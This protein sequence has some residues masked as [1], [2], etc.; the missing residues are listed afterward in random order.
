MA[1]SPADVSPVEPGFGI[2]IPDSVYT[3]RLGFFSMDANVPGLSRVIL[4]KLNM[5][6]FEDYS[7]AFD[8]VDHDILL[9]RCETVFGVSDTALI[10]FKSY[11]T[12]P[13][14][15]VSLRASVS[16]SRP[17]VHQTLVPAQTAQLPLPLTGDTCNAF[18]LPTGVSVRNVVFPFFSF[19]CGVSLYW[20]LFM[21]HVCRHAFC[22]AL[23]YCYRCQNVYYCSK[24]CQRENWPEHKKFCQQLR[25][26]AIDR[27]VEWLVFTGDIPFPSVQWPRPVAEVGG[28]EDW[29]FM[30][31]DLGP[32]L[33]AILACRHMGLLWDNAGKPRPGDAELRESVKRVASEFLSRPLALGLGLRLFGLD[34]GSRALT[35]H[36]V[37]ASH[38]ETLG[39]RTTDLDELSRMFPGHQGLEVVMVGPEVVDGPVLRPPLRALG[40]RGKVYIS[41]YKGLYHQFWEELVEQ[42]EAARPDLVVGFHPALRTFIQRLG[43]SRRQQLEGFHAA[44][45]LTE[46]WLPTLLLLRDYRIPSLFTMYNEQE[47]KYSL[48]ILTELEVQIVKCGVNPFASLKPEQVQSS[49]NKPPVYCN[50]HYVSFHG[51]LEGFEIQQEEE[52]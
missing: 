34:P 38:S 20:F 1:H 43:D 12:D 35:V 16:H 25:L 18:R 46:G 19:Q 7:A 8:T 41:A 49:P 47:L 52:G 36:L 51:P 50:S 3:D 45:G 23:V 30:Q 9:S 40:P 6:G 33:A 24:E 4:N 29:F 11:L 13:C 28:W 2:P 31:G 10:W 17:S 15:F 39:A 37:G 21:Q 27:L 48:Q 14:H 5:R 22:T 42:K 32:R 26:V 44:Q